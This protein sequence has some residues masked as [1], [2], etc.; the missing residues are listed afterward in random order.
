MY[1]TAARLTE[2]SSIVSHV[3]ASGVQVRRFIGLAYAAR[4]YGADAHAFTAEARF[5]GR[6]PSAKETRM[7]HSEAVVA[8]C[9]MKIGAGNSGGKMDPSSG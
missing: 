4:V 9:H 8:S 6:V 5:K 3:F 2:C 1:M 7:S